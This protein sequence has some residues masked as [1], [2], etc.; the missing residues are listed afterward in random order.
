MHLSRSF[1]FAGIQTPFEFA[2]IKDGVVQEGTFKRSD[3]NDFLKSN[4]M[5]RLFPDNII[6]Q[7]L[8]LSVVFPE[9]T[10]YV[11]GSM[12]WMLGGS[13]LFSL[14]ILATFGT[15]SLLYYQAEKDF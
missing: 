4:Y 2:V 6:R 7:D 11:L 8:I 1:S 5:V 3:K 10:N 9:R 14:F 13:L 12:T 15:E